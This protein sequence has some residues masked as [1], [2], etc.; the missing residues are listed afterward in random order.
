MFPF[1]AEWC[2]MG[3]RSKRF[4]VSVS[5]ADYDALTALADEHRPPLS[6]QY[7]VNWAIQQ[8]LERAADPQLSLDL[9][10]PITPKNFKIR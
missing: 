9:G 8:L 5:E 3:A 10:N 4:T 7:L 2:V 1:G 6:L